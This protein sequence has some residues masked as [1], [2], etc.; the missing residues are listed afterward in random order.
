[1]H[2]Y[3]LL[4]GHCTG[5]PSSHSMSCLHNG[6]L[7]PRGILEPLGS[8]S[9]NSPATLFAT[10]M[11]THERVIGFPSFPP[12][13]LALRVRVW[14]ISLKPATRATPN[15][16]PIKGPKSTNSRQPVM[17]GSFA[18]SV[19]C[20]MPRAYLRLDLKTVPPALQPPTHCAAQVPVVSRPRFRLSLMPSSLLSPRPRP[21]SSC[22]DSASCPL[23]CRF[24][25]LC[26]LPGDLHTSS[27]AFSIMCTPARERGE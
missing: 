2:L 4:Q 14:I 26:A 9:T 18:R 21:L 19:A 22:F 23:L 12:C 6:N 3:G 5:I 10:C 1:M 24:R 27:L 7:R 11:S 8:F 25:R 15:P 17:H 16:G 13:P 20:R